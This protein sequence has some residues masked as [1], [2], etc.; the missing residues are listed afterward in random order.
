MT[1]PINGVTRGSTPV[2]PGTGK[3]KDAVNNGTADKAGQGSGSTDVVNL[4]STAESLKGLEKS[5]ASDAE[6]SVEKVAAIKQALISGDYQ[7]NP[8]LIAEKFL[9]VERALGKV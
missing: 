6:I 2:P 4:T 1:D 3:T 5:L 7:I 9:E 8:D